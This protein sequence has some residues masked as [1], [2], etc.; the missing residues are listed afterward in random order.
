MKWQGDGSACDWNV[1]KLNE[2]KQE[3]TRKTFSS[4]VHDKDLYKKK[5]K[6]STIKYSPGNGQLNWSLNQ[7]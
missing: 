2:L 1:E 6:H 4:S 3:L 5:K 7:F